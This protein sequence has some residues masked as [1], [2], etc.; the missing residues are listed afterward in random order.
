MGSIEYRDA[1]KAV[2]DA[3][4]QT[5]TARLSVLHSAAA[6][7]A[8]GVLIEVFV[9]QDAEGPFGVW[10]RFEGADA[11]S[12]DRQLGDDRELFAVIWGEEGW[13]P[14]VPSRPSDWSRA[15]L[16]DVIVE[17]VA[18]WINPLIPPGSPDLRWEVGTSDGARDP[19]RVGPH[20]D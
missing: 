7:G 16:A 18:E 5:L 4:S 9:D 13:E 12:L 11:F 19:I 1:L 2:L 15:H 10:A 14:A 20:D 17:V 6:V 8:D 3:E